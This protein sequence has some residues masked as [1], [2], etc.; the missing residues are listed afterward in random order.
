[1]K[2]KD[3]AKKKFDFSEIK[4]YDKYKSEMDR[5]QNL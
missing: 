3:V 4:S 1:M 5:G 2:Q